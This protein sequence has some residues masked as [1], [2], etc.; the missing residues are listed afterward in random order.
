MVSFSLGVIKHEILDKLC[1][2]HISFHA[3][4]CEI[5]LMTPQWVRFCFTGGRGTINPPPHH[6]LLPPRSVHF[7]LN[8]E[9]LRQNFC[10]LLTSCFA[11]QRSF[12]R[13]TNQTVSIRLC[14][15]YVY[16]D[17]NIGCSVVCGF[18]HT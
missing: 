13:K 16:I 7:T 11:S 8:T 3:K 9:F 6:P 5:C 10:T 17:A 14:V 18:F 1:K 15:C 12:L 2:I 4:S